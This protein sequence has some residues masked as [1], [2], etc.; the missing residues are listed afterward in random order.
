M[1]APKDLTGERFGRLTVMELD[2]TPYL[3]PSGKPTR[4]WRCRCDCGNEVTVLTNA[5]TGRNGTRSCGCTRSGST[6]AALAQDLT[7][8]RFGRL[9]VLRAT[10]LPEPEPNGN[11]LGWVCRCDCG[12]EIVSTGKLLHSGR[13]L[14]CGCLLTETAYRKATEQNIF[15]HYRGTTVTAIRPTRPPNRNNTSGAKGVYWNKREQRWIARIGI[16]G[17]AI[18]LGRFVRKEDAIEAR[19]KAELQ[20]FVPIIEAYDKEH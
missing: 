16:Q 13:V 3:S 10:D 11:R 5:L 17:R 9:T 15:G 1:A 8:Q 20:Y 4:R 18:T 12:K 7:G 2:P 19:R 14:S 6:R